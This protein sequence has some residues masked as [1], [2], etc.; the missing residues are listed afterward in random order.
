MSLTITE[1]STE[2][3]DRGFDHILPA[4]RLTVLNWQIQ[5]ASDSFAFPFYVDEKSTTGGG[6][7]TF[8]WVMTGYREVLSIEQSDGHRIQWIDW[9]EGRA[10]EAQAGTGTTG[11]VKYAWIEAVVDAMELHVYP[12]VPT[13]TVTL[14]AVAEPAVLSGTN[15]VPGPELFIDAIIDLAAAVFYKEDGNASVAQTYEQMGQ[16]KLARLIK[17]YSINQSAGAVKMQMNRPGESWGG[18]Y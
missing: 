14:S 5:Q 2:L 10:L 11:S 7:I 1:A 13:T 3:S 18:D 17:R 6:A 12:Y 4:R 8:P 16:D 15:P 9:R